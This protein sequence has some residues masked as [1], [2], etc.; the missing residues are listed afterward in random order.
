MFVTAGSHAHLVG[1]LVYSVREA[2]GLKLLAR[3]AA[4]L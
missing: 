4:R 3:V 1:Y 2:E